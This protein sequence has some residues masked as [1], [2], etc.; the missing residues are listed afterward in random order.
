MTRTGLALG[1]CLAAASVFA[2]P[3][4]PTPAVDAA[5][6]AA[7]AEPMPGGALQDREFGVRSDRF[8]LE[9][10]VEMHQWRRDGA[11]YR[12]VWNAAPI[13]STGFPP[14]YL[15]PP[16]LPLESER[17]W[18]PAPTLAG[19]PLDREV[20]TALGRW[21]E[22]RP[23]FARLPANLAAAFQPEGNGLGS[24][25]NPLAPQVGDVRIRWYELTLPDLDGRVE[26]RDGTWQL[27][28]GAM[29]AARTPADPFIALPVTEARVL[30]EPWAWAVGGFAI[31]LLVALVWRGARKRDD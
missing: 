3:P 4:A 12:R 27:A 28:P 11:D 9:R 13:D 30:R 19:R 25:E 26:L 20:L 17:W 15:N 5:T 2:T 6:E 31:V 8:G 24:A 29:E 23:D 1:L 22:F 21:V 18:A 16:E 10:R 7:D 14:E